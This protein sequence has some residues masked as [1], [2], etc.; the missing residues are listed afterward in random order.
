MSIH[1]SPRD[2]RY[3]GPAPAGALPGPSPDRRGPVCPR[4]ASPRPW[5]RFLAAVASGVA[6]GRA[7][8]LAGVDEDL[9]A[10]VRAAQIG[11]VVQLTPLTVAVNL[12]NAGI[13][14]LVF[15]GRGPRWP[16]AAWFG[17]VALLAAAALRSWHTSRRRPPRRAASPRALGRIALH[18]VALAGAWGSAPAALFAAA[19][20]FGR[21]VLGCLAAGMI[22]GSAFA[23]SAVPRAGL[24]YTWTLSLLLA[25]GMAASGEPSLAAAAA[26]LCLYAAFI[27]RNLAAHGALFVEALRGRREIE[28]QREV[29]GLLLRDFEESAGDCLWETDAAGRLRRA[30]PRLAQALGLAPEAAEG[31]RLLELLSPARTGAAD[32][33]ADGGGAGAPGGDLAARLSARLAFRDVLATGRDATGEERVWSLTARPVHDRAGAFRGFRGVA[34][35]VTDRVRAETRA[36][37]LAHHDPLTGLANRRRLAEELAAALARARREGGGVALLLVDLDRFKPVN[38]LHGHAAG[39]ELLCQVAGRLRAAVRETDAVARLGGDEFALV[40][41]CA[42]PVPGADG[43]D[44]GTA[45][46]AGE[47]AARLARRVVA[48][49]ERPFALGGGALAVQ[50]GCSVGVALAPGDGDAAAALL[51]HADLAMYRAKAEGR[52]RFRFFEPEM[53]AL[54]RERAS[55]EADL[56]LAVARDELVP[57][58]Q[59]L[60]AL[61][62]GRVVGFEMLARWPHPERGMVPPTEFI[63]VAED[64]GLIG[65]LTEKLLRR[66]CRAATAWPEAVSLAVNVSPVQLRDRALPGLVRAA[67]A[68]TGLA[69]RRLEV[70][71]TESALV[72]DFDLARDVVAELKSLGVRVALDDFGT[73]YSSLKH[74]QALPFDKLKID[75]GFVRAMATDPD[76]RKIVAAVVGLGHSL[77]MPTVAEGIEEAGAAGALRGLGCDLGQG[78]LFGRPV[79]EDEAAALAAGS[80]RGSGETPYAAPDHPRKAPAA[81]RFRAAAAGGSPALRRPSPARPRHRA[82]R[83]TPNTTETMPLHRLVYCSRNALADAHADV[84][85]EVEHI[86]AVSRRNNARDGITG[87][88]L[89]GEG[90]F[91]QVLEG[92]PAA[93]ERTFERIR[94]DFRHADVLVLARG[95]VQ[96][97]LFEDWSMAYGGALGPRAAARLGLERILTEPRSPA[98][99]SVVTRL[100]DLVRGQADGVPA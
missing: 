93:V 38:D 89:Y 29:L 52:G 45:E 70:E 51:H 58:F 31:A 96:A 86:L 2:T 40:A 33:A 57:H 49:L 85:R 98:A 94:Y 37:H 28:E 75:A 67:L 99:E 65:A 91:A 10:R 81:S 19:D 24:A 32:G 14:L 69:A 66:A 84:A 54:V 77:G 15:W 43:G 87:A 20:P 56:R 39:D 53:D 95:A 88:L 8:P 21:F 34:S 9:A 44:A 1:V 22:T 3:V 60:V 42:R 35:D 72:A 41:H 59:P 55:L 76:S 68:E 26:M 47:D 17:L 11:A 83:G 73:G 16:L 63:P 4:P 79:A 62:T 64:G 5:T 13:V 25:G 46:G 92:P 50:V 100:Q 30:P 90:C 78:Y 74:L 27:S 82:T 36:A 48:A 80:D 18:A 12:L 23:L 7:D 97:R 6:G 61:D 71:L